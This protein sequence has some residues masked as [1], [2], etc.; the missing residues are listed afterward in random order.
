MLVRL[1]GQDSDCVVGFRKNG[2][3]KA[4]AAH[5]QAQARAFGAATEETTRVFRACWYRTGS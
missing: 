5:W 3:L 2:V 4:A 1:D